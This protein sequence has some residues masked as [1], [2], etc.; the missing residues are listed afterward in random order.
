MAVSGG[1][2]EVAAFA[3]A[4]AVHRRGGR[5]SDL[6]E[7]AFVNPACRGRL[8][9]PRSDGTFFTGTGPSLRPGWL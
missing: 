8:C 4:E 7:G 6:G 3:A 5:G 2:A 1:G 9:P